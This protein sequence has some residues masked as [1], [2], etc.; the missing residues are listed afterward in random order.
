MESEQRKYLV[1][2]FLIISLIVAGGL[3]LNK[4]GALNFNIW[5]DFAPPGVNFKKIAVTGDGNT[6][7]VGGNKATTGGNRIW[8]LEKRD[9]EKG[10]AAIVN[11]GSSHESPTSN[12][13]DMVTDANNNIYLLGQSNESLYLDKLDSA[14]NNLWTY[15]LDSSRPRAIFLDGNR[16]MFAASCY[17]C[18]TGYADKY[19]WRVGALS[20]SAGTPIVTNQPVFSFAFSV[21]NSAPL[22]LYVS[23]NQVFVGGF[24]EQPPGSNNHIEEAVLVKLNYSSFLSEFAIDSSF[25]AGGVL[26]VDTGRSGL[27]CWTRIESIVGDENSLYLAGEY[28][29]PLVGQLA[30][31]SVGF[32]KKISFGGNYVIG[33]GKNGTIDSNVAAAI[34]TLDI[35]GIS[36]DALVKDDHLYV[37]GYHLYLDRG[38]HFGFLERISKMQGNISWINKGDNTN[39]GWIR[40]IT[41]HGNVFYYGGDNFIVKATESLAGQPIRAAHVYNARS[42]I[43]ETLNRAGLPQIN[44]TENIVS[45]ELIRADDVNELISGLRE[46]CPAKAAELNQVNPGDIISRSLFDSL[47]L[48]IEAISDLIRNRISIF[49]GC[50][51]FFN[52][53]KIVFVTSQT[54]NGNLQASQHGEPAGEGGILKGFDG[55]DKKCQYSADQAG[56][57]S[58]TSRTYKA[59]LS[60]RS[61]EDGGESQ[62]IHAVERINPDMSK[63]YY[64]PDGTKIADDWADLTDGTLDNIININ[65][66]GNVVSQSRFLTF[67]NTT[68]DGHLHSSNNRNCA[69]GF[70]GNGVI[71]WNSSSDN[72]T[73]FYG[74]VLYTHARWTENYDG[75]VECDTPLRLYCFEQ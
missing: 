40:F 41:S 48:T 68:R 13:V 65:E 17:G 1:V 72:K 24:R 51:T 2:S 75:H 32:V 27:Q 36:Y 44:F 74:E 46:S 8:Y 70:G 58:Q 61:R 42:V 45:G 55:A 15:H 53:K 57:G 59:W 3:F 63:S 52:D 43:N 56:I 6:V 73:A 18:V 22:D 20:A 54:Y 12:I 25:G 69:S 16:V 11:L 34:P 30:C 21:Y 67:T 62:N 37:T 28:S 50:S 71:P 35:R 47:G 39:G 31:T 10:E 66:W 38:Y 9:P 60:G 29:K 49:F 33:F 64:A 23:G 5:E 7:Y 26:V 4:A 19:T 14:G